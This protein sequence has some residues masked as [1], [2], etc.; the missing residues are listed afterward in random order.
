VGLTGL[1]QAWQP[2]PI[3]PPARRRA[4]GLSRSP[5]HQ[6]PPWGHGCVEAGPGRGPTGGLRSWPGCNMAAVI[7]LC[8]P[9][10]P[11]A[12]PPEGWDVLRALR[13][14][15]RSFMKSDEQ[16]GGTGPPKTQRNGDQCFIFYTSCSHQYQ[17]CN[18]HASSILFILSAV[19]EHHP[20]SQSVAIIHVF[21]K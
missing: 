20:Y 18:V 5:G 14:G 16:K 9:C 1:G 4:A 21:L 3:P 10:A 15:W 13:G 8:G 11:A 17:K 6:S 12:R 7:F 2:R 19:V